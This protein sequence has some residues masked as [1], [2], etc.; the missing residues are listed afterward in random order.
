[1]KSWWNWL[2][3]EVKRQ[4]NAVTKPPKTA[5]R[6]VDFLRQIPIVIGE[7]SN[8]RQ[9]DVAPNHPEKLE[10]VISTSVGYVFNIFDNS[11]EKYISFYYWAKLILLGVTKYSTRA[12]TI[13]I[14]NVRKYL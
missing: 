4:P 8:E 12:W 14:F 5:V 6:R 7:I 9:V 1:M 13:W 3:K 10:E 11:L 2:A